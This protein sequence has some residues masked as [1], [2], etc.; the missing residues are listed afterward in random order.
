[1][2]NTE[3]RDMPPVALPPDLADA[4]RAWHDEIGWAC[5]AHSEGQGCCLDYLLDPTPDQETYQP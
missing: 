5:V 4:L 3:P 1:M 2:P